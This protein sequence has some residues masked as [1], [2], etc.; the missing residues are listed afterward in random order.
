MKS[1]NPAL[2]RAV[3]YSFYPLIVFGC[4]AVNMMLFGYFEKKYWPFIPLLLVF[5]VIIIIEI[6]E[7]Y[8]PYKKEWQKNQGDA[9][10][11][12]VQTFVSVPLASKIIENILPLILF[13]PAL[14]VR[15]KIGINIWSA[16]I[17]VL[18]QLFIILL[19]AEFCFYWIHRFSHTNKFLW[20]FH[21]VHH[22]CERV[23]WI[24]SG[25]FH[26]LDT[27][28]DSLF[29]FFPLVLFGA[30]VEVMI[31]F[32]GLSA[33]TGF[34]EHAN[35]DFRA[36]Y[37][38]YFFNTAQ[39]HRWHHSIEVRESN[40]NFGKIISVWD[41]VF[42]TFYFPKEKQINKVGIQDKDKVPNSIWGQLKYPFIKKN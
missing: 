20:R 1:E 34:L 9:G 40:S 39:L 19:M 35:V 28:I 27:L 4:L 16:G 32:I 7:R 22:A 2:I 36:G 3:Q 26:F 37:L 18:L 5:G 33:V 14:W 29:F 21:A 41:I 25:R 13:Y 38:N 10:A 23:Y 17:P 6:G 24:N 8:L 15:N 11:D 30:P 12:F 31:L 42:G